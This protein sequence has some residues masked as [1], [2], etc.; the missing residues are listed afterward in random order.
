[1]PT[2]PG[3]KFRITAKCGVPTNQRA[4]RRIAM[5]VGCTSLIGVGPGF[6]PILA[7]GAG[8]RVRLTDIRS[9]A[10]S[11]RRLMYRS[12]AS[13]A[14]SD[15]A[16]VSAAGAELVGCPW[17]HAT[18]SIRGGAVGVVAGSARSDSA[19]ITAAA[20]LRCMAARASRT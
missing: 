2:A 16:P 4:G 1:M 19:T 11:G 7:A 12:L 8:G 13:V 15:L 3:R 20:L 10:R 18:V 5:G 9:I 14:A 17:D 6:P